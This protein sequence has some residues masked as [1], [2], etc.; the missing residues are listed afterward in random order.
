MTTV[1]TEYRDE[2]ETIRQGF[3]YERCSDCEGDLGEHVIAP[4]PLGHA[5]AWCQRETDPGDQHVPA[6]AA[7]SD[8]RAVEV[9]SADL[10]RAAEIT[11]NP[12]N[13]DDPDT[14]DAG[15]W[16]RE[17]VAWDL[18]QRRARA[19]NGHDDADGW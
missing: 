7:S 5:H 14:Y 13:R 2:V 3:E 18:A 12:I 17:Q 8:D 1:D 6:D 4:D 9:A 10:E 11:G 19:D 15:R 16:L